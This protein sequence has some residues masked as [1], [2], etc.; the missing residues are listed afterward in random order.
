MMILALGL[1]VSPSALASGLS[2]ELLNTPASIRVAADFSGSDCGAK[3]MNAERDLGTTA[4]EIWVDQSCG[5]T[6]KTGITLGASHTLRFVQGGVYSTSVG[7]SLRGPLSVVVG[8]PA[9]SGI[10]VN[11]AQLVI[12]AADNANLDSV[13]S[14]SGWGAII[15][16]VLIDGNKVNN[17]TSASGVALKIDK[18]NRVGIRYVTTQNAKSHGI[19]IFS[20]M[21]NEACCG[22]MVGVMSIDNGG[23]GLY[24]E[25]S[26][27]W[28][29]AQ[30]EFEANSLH[31][32]ESLDSATA[33]ITNSDFG[34]NLQDGV[35]LVS[36][37]Q[38]N[39]NANGWILNG[40]Q[41]GNNYHH[42]FYANGAAR[43]YTNIAHVLTGNFFLGGLQADNIYDTIHLEDSGN[44][45]I[46]GNFFGGGGAHRYR[47]QIFEGDHGYALPSTVV[48]NVFNA[49]GAASGPY[50]VLSTTAVAANNEMNAGTWLLQGATL[51]NGASLLWKD[52]TGTARSILGV[53][54]SNTVI[55][56]GHPVRRVLS[57]QASP[58]SEVLKVTESGI[59]VALGKTATFQGG[60]V[61]P[62][63]QTTLHTPTTSSSPCSMGQVWADAD[64][65]YVCSAPNKIKRAA[66]NAF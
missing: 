19:D 59:S 56:E 63:W 12:K 66:L 14:L 16:N 44:L 4:G 34:G 32:V 37:G 24:L 47:Y 18:A 26:A 11:S 5:V 52:S 53:D 50:K 58:G 13:V 2:E 38:Q 23:D 62:N 45:T 7:L 9:P 29:I 6:W 57:F 28:F 35:H 36:S 3:I 64:Y 40:N 65:I 61:A 51:A 15:E 31:G 30:S 48:G 54:A 22:K 49:G 20:N 21:A 46:A 42:D 55:V 43:R 10:G 27:D 33:R 25:R 60:M 8:P 1:C 41:F 39:L 17:G